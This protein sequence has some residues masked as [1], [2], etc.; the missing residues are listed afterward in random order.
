MAS[1]NKAI[2]VVI[3]A[4]VLVAVLYVGS[5]LSTDEEV[6][7]TVAPAERYRANQPGAEDI[8][9]GDQSIQGLMQTVTIAAAGHKAASELIHNFV[10]AVF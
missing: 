6:T 1:S 4:V 8:Q 2:P 5:N 3:G 10:H 9:L 7:G